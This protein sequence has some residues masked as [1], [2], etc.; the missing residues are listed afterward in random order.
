MHVRLLQRPVSLRTLRTLRGACAIGVARAWPDSGVPLLPPPRR[1]RVPA[2]T[3]GSRSS[4]SVSFQIV[5]LS[6]LAVRLLCAVHVVGTGRPRTTLAASPS[7]TRV[8]RLWLR[9]A[10]A[11]SGSYPAG[12]AP[13]ASRACARAVRTTLRSAERQPG[14]EYPA[15]SVSTGFQYHTISTV[16]HDNVIVA[17]VAAAT[18]CHTQ[19]HGPGARTSFIAWA[20]NTGNWRTCKRENKKT[21]SYGVQVSVVR[22]AMSLDRR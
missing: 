5:T 14:A 10:L 4:C 16:C 17:A 21:K 3:R 18:W 2:S 20:V 12:L 9:P 7:A 19:C 11:V 6:T 15:R 1:R 22:F 13:L 8:R